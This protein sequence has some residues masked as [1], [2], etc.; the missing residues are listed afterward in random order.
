[1]KFEQSIRGGVSF[2]NHGHSIANNQYLKGLNKRFNLTSLDVKEYD[3]SKPTKYILYLDMNN[4]YGF[5][6]TKALP[7]GDFKNSS[8]ETI[9]YVFNNINKDSFNW[10]SDDSDKGAMCGV[11][12]EIPKDKHDYFRDFPLAAV[13]RNGKLCLTLEDKFN[14]GIHIACL[15]YFISKGLI[16]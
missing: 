4:L 10:G 7:Y 15:K 9:E 2:I 3:K 8:Q 16:L 1:M 6:M 11:D 14:Y 13:H 12:L 5:I